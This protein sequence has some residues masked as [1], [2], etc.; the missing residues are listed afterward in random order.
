MSV[1]VSGATISDEWCHGSVPS[2]A[3]PRSAVWASFRPPAAAP[4][5]TDGSSLPGS[6]LCAAARLITG[7]LC[8]PLPPG[9]TSPDLS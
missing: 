5:R 2:L 7:M 6:L 3:A 1:S 4:P 9:L 8:R